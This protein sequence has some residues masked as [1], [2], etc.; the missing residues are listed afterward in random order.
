MTGIRRETGRTASDAAPQA[1]PTATAK[2]LLDVLRGPRVRLRPLEEGDLP[3]TRAWRNRDDVRCWFRTTAPIS[4]EQHRDWWRGYRG[5]PDDLVLVIEARGLD[6]SGAVRALGMLSI[7]AIN[8]VA[9]TAEFGRLLLGERDASGRGLAIEATRLLLDW[10][11]TD[12]GLRRVTLEVRADNR[13]AIALYERLGFS[14]DSEGDG[15]LAMSL[16]A[17]TR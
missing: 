15:W 1:V 13:R 8:Q 3:L 10:A 7:Y 11:W 9:G 5:R 4:E 14:V 16:D 6:G 17:A 12:L 2:P